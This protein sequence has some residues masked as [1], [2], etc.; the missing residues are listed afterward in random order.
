[1]ATL[2]AIYISR[3]GHLI[4]GFF[5]HVV[6]RAGVIVSLNASKASEHPPAR[7]GENGR[8]QNCLEEKCFFLSISVTWAKFCC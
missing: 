2:T 5:F 1:M 6:V 8:P 7:Q 3:C 4:I